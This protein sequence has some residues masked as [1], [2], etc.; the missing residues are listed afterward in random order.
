[1]DQDV[2]FAGQADLGSDGLP[3]LDGMIGSM[4]SR[5]W[6]ES[7]HPGIR[8]ITEQADLHQRPL[9]LRTNSYISAWT[10]TDLFIETYIQTGNRVGFEHVTGA[11]MKATLENIVYPPM[12]GVEQIDYQG[13]AR[14]AL[15][16][17]RIGEMN[18][19]GKD[20]K[21]PAGANNPPM[22]VT[23][24]DQQF[25]VPMIVP[26]TDF[27]TAPDLRP[28]GADVPAAMEIAPT[29]ASEST[30]TQVAL[31]VFEGTIAFRSNRTG[32][33]EIYVINGDDSELINLTN[34]PSD[35]DPP[36]GLAIRGGHPVRDD[37][38]GVAVPALT[39]EIQPHPK[40][41]GA[42]QGAAGG[43]TMLMFGRRGTMSA[44]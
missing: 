34:N 42:A 1:L 22:V 29:N 27:Q 5:S 15:S 8:L 25:L 26:M 32:N 12:A 10:M 44:L 14:R 6:A 40:A 7:D 4:P 43:I 16:T 9:T 21:T 17:N 41:A 18:F 28:G 37:R 23:V 20:G 30:V 19:L 36:A 13:G 31:G 38:A 24:G 3:M 39:R 33:N 2:V 35:D 11:D